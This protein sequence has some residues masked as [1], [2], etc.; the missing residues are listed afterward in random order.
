MECLKTQK[1]DSNDAVLY[2]LRKKKLKPVT[3]LMA[4]GSYNKFMQ[5]IH[6]SF[7]SILCY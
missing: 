1:E 3:K 7:E 6:R 2:P 4:S 5:Q